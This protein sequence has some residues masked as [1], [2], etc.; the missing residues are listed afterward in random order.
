MALT[1]EAAL[2][3]KFTNMTEEEKQIRKS[4]GLTEL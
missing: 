3:F 1:R 2:S 4:G